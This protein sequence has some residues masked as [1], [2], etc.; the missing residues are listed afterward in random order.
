MLMHKTDLRGRRKS[1]GRFVLAAL[2]SLALLPLSACGSDINT[3]EVD[4]SKYESGS[5]ESG[6]SFSEPV[7]EGAAVN[8]PVTS[9]EL[10]ESPK[11]SSSMEESSKEES[12]KTEPLP[13]KPSLTDAEI[14][15][16]DNTEH[17]F[18]QGV[19]FDEQNRPAGALW[20]NDDYEK[21]EA[22]AL[23][24][25]ESRSKNI[26]LTFDQ[27]YEN[28]Y[29]IPILDVLKE[30][31]ATAT[32]FI[33]GGYMK[34]ADPAIIQ[35]MIDDG[36]VLG[37]HGDGHKSLAELLSANG[38]D[39]A[40]AE[41]NN[42]RDKILEDYGYECV[43]VRPPAGKYSERSLA[44]TQSLGYKSFLWSFAYKDWEVDNQPDPEEAIEKITS[45]PHGGGIFLLHSVSAT[46]AAVLGRVIDSL[47]A[48]GYNL[49]GLDV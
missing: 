46:N 26:Y 47:Q 30:K 3:A 6:G 17:D 10:D 27:G 36:H 23:I 33:T 28:G 48:Q 39:A 5:E 37:V 43:Y 24:P 25:D 14:D 31:G 49:C 21:Y 32:F 16:L 11:E 1:G 13:D 42:V 34:Y 38:K 7:E 2:C 4:W 19:Q 40:A 41:L 12:S 22:W 45:H 15:A 29:T 44:F 35:R 18:G 20:F 8:V 9:I